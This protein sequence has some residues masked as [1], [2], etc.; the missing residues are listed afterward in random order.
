MRKFESLGRKLSRTEQR[1][2]MGGKSQLVCTCNGSDMLTTVCPFE[3]LTGLLNCFAAAGSY[4]SSQGYSGI[5][6]DG[7]SGPQ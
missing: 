4:C 3:T 6:C 5:S 1:Q 7:G 2:I